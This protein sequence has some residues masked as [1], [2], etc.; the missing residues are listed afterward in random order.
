M[1]FS[2]FSFV[3]D[4]GVTLRLLSCSV[5]GTIQTQGVY[6]ESLFSILYGLWSF[7]EEGFDWVPFNIHVRLLLRSS[8]WLLTTRYPS[9]P[10]IFL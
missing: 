2:H 3:K 10:F 7:L 9:S 4:V 1:K 8:S 5:Q 6:A